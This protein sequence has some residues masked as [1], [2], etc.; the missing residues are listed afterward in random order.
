ME[1][2]ADFVSDRGLVEIE[3]LANALSDQAEGENGVSCGLCIRPWLGR[4]PA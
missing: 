3:G 4:S 2:P 1:Y